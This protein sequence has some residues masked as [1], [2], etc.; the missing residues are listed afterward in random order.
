MS[1]SKKAKSFEGLYCYACERPAVSEEHAPSRGFY[2]RRQEV[3]GPPKGKDYRKGLITVPSCEEHNTLKAQDDNFVQ[4]AI[5]LFAAAYGNR[6][7]EANPHPFVEKAVKRIQSGTRLRE[8][9]IDNAKPVDTPFGP[10]MAIKPEAGTIRRIIELTARALYYHEY[11]HAR[12]WPGECR[13]ESPHFLLDNLSPAPQARGVSDVLSAFNELYRRGIEKFALKGP[14]RDVFA[15]QLLEHEDQS[16]IMRLT[17]YGV[18]HFVAL[19]RHADPAR[20]PDG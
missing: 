20:H 12:R 3:Y 14:H 11:K 1:R 16:I 4:A 19:G 5:I 6:L 7:G 10:M 9:I 8:S 17:F 15:Y 18:F 2:P 13:I